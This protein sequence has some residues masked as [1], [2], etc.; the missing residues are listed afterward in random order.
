MAM[1]EMVKNFKRRRGGG[2]S[3]Y[4]AQETVSWRN[5]YRQVR[6]NYGTIAEEFRVFSDFAL[7]LRTENEFEVVPVGRLLDAGEEADAGKKVRVSLRFDIDADPLT[8]LLLAR[9]LCRYGLPSCFFLLHTAPYYGQFVG[10]KF[11]RSSDL[12]AY[13]NELASAGCEVGLHT[14]PYTIYCEQAIDGAQ[15][16]VAEIA[17]LRSHSVDV[18][19]TCAH[20]SF[21]RWGVAS[22]EIFKEY[23]LW[24]RDVRSP[25][26]WKFPLGTLSAVDMG[27]RC[28]ATFAV[29]KAEVSKD[30]VTLA[31][32]EG[33]GA[34]YRGDWLKWFLIHNPLHDFSV[35]LQVWP[36]GNEGWRLGGFWSGEAV[37][38]KMGTW[39][40]VLD[41]LKGKYL[42][43]RVV[44]VM[45]PCYFCGD[46][47]E[48]HDR[49][50]DKLEVRKSF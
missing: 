23:V 32:R 42:G 48:T 28:E 41:K 25:E 9:V 36:M 6:E 38:A 44:F 39:R 2:W 30:E 29:P 17:W 14:D 16:L 34:A 33:V 49:M 7:A 10:G 22:S 24:D 19:S 20:N 1:Q 31:L 13:L 11:V 4:S 27:L 18:R 40:D 3:P 12:P 50:L 26:G 35:D 47:A 37:Y 8:G 21:S 15:A 46:L 43:A 45:H 5:Y